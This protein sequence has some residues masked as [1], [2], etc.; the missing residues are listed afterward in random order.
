MPIISHGKTK[1][2][3]LLALLNL[4][5]HQLKSN[6]PRIRPRTSPHCLVLLRLRRIFEGR[7][8]QIQAIPLNASDASHY[9]AALI[10]SR[11]RLFRVVNSEAGKSF[12]RVVGRE[13]MAGRVRRQDDDPKLAILAL[14]S[15]VAFPR[16]PCSV[17]GGRSFRNGSQLALGFV[18]LFR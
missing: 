17:T 15:L 6:R 9:C 1:T 14:V 7:P 10:A 12:R 11:L 4:G 18:C 3:C 8:S 13:S 16:R 2:N 5:R